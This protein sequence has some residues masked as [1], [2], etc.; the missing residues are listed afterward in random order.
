MSSAV[1]RAGIVVPAHDE[2]ALIGR[3]LSSLRIAAD[4]ASVPV[5]IVVVLDSCTDGTL[6]VCRRHGVEV[7]SIAARNVGAARATGASVLLAAEAAPTSVWLATTDADCEVEP[8]WLGHQIDLARSG[9][10]VVLGLI[11]LHDD[12]LHESVRRTFQDHYARLVTPGRGHGHVHGANLGLR[13]STYLRVGGFSRLSNHEDHDLVQ[14]LGGLD[15]VTIRRSLLRP[16]RTSARIQG[17]CD[18][19]VAADLAG[20][21][22]LPTG[23]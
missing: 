4:R 5:R 10:D 11:G 15:R 16:V 19:G 1:R 3:C 2:E 6:D 13:G 18:Q 8:D 22:A 20:L 17:R 23:A 7:R 12:P 14:R 9:A 21:A